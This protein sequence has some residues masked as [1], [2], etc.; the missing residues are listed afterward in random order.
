MRSKN[1]ATRSSS[2]DEEALRAR[3]VRHSCRAFWRKQ[4][5]IWLLLS[6]PGRAMR[7][8]SADSFREERDPYFHRNAATQSTRRKARS[9]LWIG[10]GDS[11]RSSPFSLRFPRLGVSIL[12]KTEDLETEEARK[13]KQMLRLLKTWSGTLHGRPGA[14]CSSYMKNRLLHPLSQ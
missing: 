2:R 1:S 3:E 6:S 5:L 12:Q 4:L 13:K 14:R 10:L 11:S 9:F 7:P 8:R